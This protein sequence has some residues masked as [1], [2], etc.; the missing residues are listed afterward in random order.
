MSE[1]S[2]ISGGIPQDSQYFGSVGILVDINDLS[3]STNLKLT[4]FADDTM[5]TPELR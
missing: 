5:Y 1:C 2:T 4:M 3:K